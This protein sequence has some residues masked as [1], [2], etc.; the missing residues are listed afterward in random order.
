[1]NVVVDFSFLTFTAH[2]G[3]PNKF[4]KL[5]ELQ[6]FSRN[7]SISTLWRSSFSSL[8]FIILSKDA[9]T[10]IKFFSTC[11]E[12]GLL[13][14]N[15]WSMC[16]CFFFTALHSADSILVLS[17]RLTSSNRVN[18]N[19]NGLLWFGQ[20]GF[21]FFII[22]LTVLDSWSGCAYLSL[23]SRNGHLKQFVLSFCFQNLGLQKVSFLFHI[24]CFRLPIFNFLSLVIFVF[25]HFDLVL[26]D[27]LNSLLEVLNFLIF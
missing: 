9:H 5:L 21:S 18:W 23:Q 27:A 11:C 13:S 6:V 15:V 25:L 19:V 3:L 20:K 4:H 8:F 16:S 26:L 1:M 14:T 12:I 7:V 24:R 22:I 2:F 17:F 10:Y